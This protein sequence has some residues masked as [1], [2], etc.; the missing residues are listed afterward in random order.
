MESFTA[1]TVRHPGCRPLRHPEV[2]YLQNIVRNAADENRS[3]LWRGLMHGVLFSSAFW[4]GLAIW[5]LS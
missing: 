4:L 5:V 3:M 1:R 2:E